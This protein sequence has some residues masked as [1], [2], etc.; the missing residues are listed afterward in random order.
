MKDSS[1][2]KRIQRIKRAA[3]TRSKIFGTQKKPR[4]SIF[5]S[6]KH[7]Y[8]QLIDD[9]KGKTL[10]HASDLEL[11][12][13]ALKMKKAFL[14]GQSIAKKA[15]ELKIKEAVFSKGGYKYHGAV[16]AAAEGARAGGLKF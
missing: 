2:T 5:R 11:K 15:A 6:N 3:R 1:K 16:K 14:V 13:K 9:E 7:V 10:A 4:L 12:E 8:V